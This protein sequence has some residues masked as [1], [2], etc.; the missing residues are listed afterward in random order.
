VALRGEKALAFDA[1]AGRSP[2]S[3]RL[4]TV[5]GVSRVTVSQ[6]AELPWIESPPLVVLRLPQP[7]LPRSGA[8]P[9][10]G[11]WTYEP[12]LDGYRCLTCTHET[13]GALGRSRF[14]PGRTGD[15]GFHP[16]ER[17]RS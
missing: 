2:A 10:G 15:E 12:K 3:S 1:V 13:R 7:V 17:I 6:L 16:S 5:E 4:Q 8:I 9:L 11:G 14:R